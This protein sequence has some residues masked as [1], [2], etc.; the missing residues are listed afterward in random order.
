VI[1]QKEQ[2][3]GV[4]LRE[5]HVEVR[6][7]S[8][9]RAVDEREPPRQEGDTLI[10]PVFEYVPVV[11]MQLM[12]KEEVHVTTTESVQQVVRAVTLSAEELVVERREGEDGEWQAEHKD[13]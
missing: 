2:P 8:I 11:R 9:N 4:T 7:V 5:Q 12:L 1:H 3:L 13:S 6:R 10:I